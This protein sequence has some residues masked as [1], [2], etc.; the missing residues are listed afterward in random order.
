MA[1]GSALEGHGVA[2]PR[3]RRFDG[4]RMTS[5]ELC[6]YL[7]IH[8]ATLYGLLKA[9]KIPHFL[10]GADYRFNRESI[11]EWRNSGSGL[12]HGTQ[13]RPADDSCPQPLAHG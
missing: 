12:S 9:G 8:R 1:P 13:S 2:Q 7:R 4:H 5:G 11:E 10:V 6:E 3:C